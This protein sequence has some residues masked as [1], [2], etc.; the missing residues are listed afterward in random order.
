MVFRGMT[1][2]S[3]DEVRTIDML[4]FV[5]KDLVAMV[6]KKKAITMEDALYYIYSSDFYHTLLDDKAKTWYL[7]T[8]SMYEMLEKQKAKERKMCKSD[9]AIM[10]FKMFCIENYRNANNLSSRET[11]LIFTKYNV[12]SFLEENFEV[13][14]TQDPSYIIDTVGVYIKKRKK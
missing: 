11:L 4:P 9:K 8:I 12:F 3:Q 2:K 1:D 14:H 6:M 13:L 7:S 5:M 10:L